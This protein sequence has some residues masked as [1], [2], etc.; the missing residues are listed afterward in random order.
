VR[1]ACASLVD[2]HDELVTQLAFEHFIG[3]PDDRV[4]DSFVQAT[5]RH[6]RLRGGFLDENGCGDQFRLRAQA[7]D[8]EV[9][10][11]PG[12]LDSVIGVGGNDKLP[13]GIALGPEWHRRPA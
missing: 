11:G 9:F 4:A 6:V 10:E 2:V 3:S 1:R 7:A 8:W 12:G 13:K 5:Q